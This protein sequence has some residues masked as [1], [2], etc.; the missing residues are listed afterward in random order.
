MKAI[1]RSLV[2]VLV[3]LIAVPALV[4][5]VTVTTAVQLLAATAFVMGGTQHPLSNPPDTDQFIADYLGLA[6]DHYIEPAYGAP[7]NAVPVVYP[8][9]FF[10]TFGSMTFDDSVAVGRD[11]LN[12]CLRG[13]ACNTGTSNAPIPTPTTAD[14]FGYSQSAVVASLVKGD[15]IANPAGAPADTNFILIANPM[16]P[17]GGILGRG[18]EGMT[19]PIFGITFYGPTPNSCGGPECADNDPTVYDTT[20]V[21]QQYDFLGGDAPARPLNV[22]AMANSLAAY[23]QLHGDVPNHYLGEPGMINQGEYGDT[24][25][26]L[27]PADRLPI[28]MPLE[29]LGVPSAALALPDAILRVWIED[30]YIRDQSPGQHVQFQIIPIGNPVG[31]IGNTLGAIP[32][33]IDD[34]FQQATG[35]DS[36]P[37]G[38]ADVYRPFGVGGTVYDKESGEPTDDNVGIPTGTGNYGSTTSV[39]PPVGGNTSLTA[40]NETAKVDNSEITT[41]TTGTPEV[42]RPRPL[43]VIR[44]SLNFDPTKRPTAVRPSGDGPISRVVKALTGQG[45]KAT[46]EPEA[47]KPESKPDAA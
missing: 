39:Q 32:V 36:R 23:A 38:T 2:V 6:Q 25:Y 35:T 5:S 20:D 42:T 33:G 43:Q 19:I 10:P 45:S 16:R 27:I 40:T 47:D 17:N 30:A 11:N 41:P 1:A 3:A 24:Q 15:L 44:E 18:F 22:L 13:L 4:I 29:S 12:K 21:A 7:A 8:A 31:L 28:L 9:E 37:L 34:T 46:S 14:V 26:Y